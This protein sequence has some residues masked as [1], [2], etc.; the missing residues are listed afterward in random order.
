[1]ITSD[2]Q[3]ELPGG[4][5]VTLAV[6]NG[7]EVH[8]FIQWDNGRIHPCAWSVHTG[9]PMAGLMYSENTVSAMYEPENKQVD[10]DDWINLM[11]LQLAK[12]RRKMELVLIVNHQGSV[13]SMLPSG[14]HVPK[15]Y[16][17]FARITITGVIKEGQEIPITL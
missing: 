8:G 4:H 13:R 12:E 3:Y 11:T 2:K 14:G 10:I 7:I 6:F 16:D 15:Q 1:M 9:M 17:E 5:K